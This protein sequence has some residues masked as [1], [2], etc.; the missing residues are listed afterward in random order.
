MTYY[1][2]E[3]NQPEKTAA[4]VEI[5]L[6]IPQDEDLRQ[7]IADSYPLDNGFACAKLAASIDGGETL[8]PLVFDNGTKPTQ[9]TAT[10][11][12]DVAKL[13]GFEGDA[14]DFV[15][16]F[17]NI[18]V[19]TQNANAVT[20][21]D[22]LFGRYAAF[23]VNKPVPL[24]GKNL[25]VTTPEG[26]SGHI[27]VND[28]PEDAKLTLTKEVTGSGYTWSQT[29]WTSSD[30]TIATIRADGVIHPLRTG[31]VTFYLEAVSMVG[32]QTTKAKTT[33]LQASH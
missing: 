6:D 17:Y 8:I 12:I 32:W 26:W 29:K 33:A 30:E 31:E 3:G 1:P 13:V 19:D 28:P 4:T 16:E 5:T 7:L 24:T 18:T 25:V 27:Y 10:A 20:K 11:E 21:G 14:K 15:M 9:M 22:L 23:S 2:P